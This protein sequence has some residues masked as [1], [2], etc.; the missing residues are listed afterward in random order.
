MR[1]IAIELDRHIG[2]QTSDVPLERAALEAM[3]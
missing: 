1:R 2:A 3:K